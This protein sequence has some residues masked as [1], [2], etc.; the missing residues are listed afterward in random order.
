[1]VFNANA[2][3]WKSFTFILRFVESRVTEVYVLSIAE[4]LLDPVDGFVPCTGTERV[5]NEKQE[6]AG[7]R[8]AI[9]AQQC[10]ELLL[11]REEQSP[12]GCQTTASI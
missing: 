3:S 9:Q 6:H 5:L 11:A 4:I 1:M 7:L 8:R 12:L 10:M 2:Q